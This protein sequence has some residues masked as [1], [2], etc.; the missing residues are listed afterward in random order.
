VLL[1]LVVIGCLSAL[2][3]IAWADRIALGALSVL[4]FLLGGRMMPRP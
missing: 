3:D 1:L 4:L 2:Y